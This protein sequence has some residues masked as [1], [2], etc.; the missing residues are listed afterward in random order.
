VLVSELDGV[1]EKSA[2]LFRDLGIETAR[3]LLD[4]FPF[5]YDDLREPM[6]SAQ[7]RVAANDG[8]GEVNALGYVVDVKERRARS[9]LEIVEVRAEDDSGAF[10]AKWIGYHRYAI[11]RFH[12]GMR[13]FVR[14]RLDRALL[15]PIVNV[16]HYRVLHDD[17]PYR[18]EMVPV[19]R[20]SKDLPSR[21]IASVVKKNFASLLR[22]AGED[23]LPPQI[24]KERGFQPLLDAYAMVHVPQTPEQAQRARERFIFGEFLVLAV[25]AQLRRAQRMAEHDAAALPVPEDILA[26]LESSLPFAL[27]PSQRKV[28]AEIWQDMSRDVPMNRLLQGDVG[29]GK[30]VVAAAAVLLAAR[31]GYQSA[32]MAPTEI[33]VSQHIAKLSPLLV[34]LRVAVEPIL[35]SQTPRARQSAVDRLVSG[36]AALAVGTHALLTE[37]VEFS[38]L[39]LAIIDE[40]HRFGVEHRARLRAKGGTPHTLHMTATPIPRTLAQSLYADLDESRID[41]MPPGRTPVE[42]FAVRFAR[43]EMV[44][45]FVRAIVARGGQA[46]VVAP[47]IEEGETGAMSAVTEFERLK[48]EVFADLRLGLVHGRLPAREK[49]EVMQRFARGEIAVLVATT[50]IEVGVD[51]PNASVMVVLDAQRYGLAQLHQL[52]GRVGRGAAQSFC[53]YVYADDREEADR[54]SILT[55]TNDGFAIAE[56]DLEIRGAGEFAGTAQHGKAQLRF[57]DLARDFAV[58]ERARAAAGTIVKRDPHLRS[59]ENVGLRAALDTTPT[60]HAL[61]A[62]S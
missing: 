43:L 4:Y 5:R 38:R 8:A 23:V 31:S 46:Y 44:Y 32:L 61:L 17:E 37:D 59:P 15:E 19:Y 34:S 56:A 36:E 25:G 21:K 13:V 53:I 33:L 50:V 47:A 11:G 39:G 29:S 35:G 22:E 52:R 27:T 58:Y 24:V 6:S 20:A 16:T 40:Q 41:E 7:L 12:P 1:G 18:G 48:T 45:A 62:S 2:R 55:K 51:V 49:E 14:G 42:T 9:G 28:I 26:E 54:L 60:L 3:D 10:V 57:G 30:T